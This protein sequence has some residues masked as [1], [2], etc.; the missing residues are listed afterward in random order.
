MKTFLMLLLSIIACSARAADVRA[1]KIDCRLEASKEILSVQRV[2][3]ATHYGT[4]A[5]IS[6]NKDTEIS[7]HVG[8]YGEDIWMELQIG[9]GTSF[10]S[11]SQSFPRIALASPNGVIM[12]LWAENPGT[13]QKEWLACNL[14]KGDQHDD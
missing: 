7:G 9:H 6:S 12:G 14:K 5:Y 4:F 3:P 13:H 10:T 11:F 1:V 2:N 8:V